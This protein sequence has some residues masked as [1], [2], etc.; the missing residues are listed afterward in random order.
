MFL[1]SHRILTPTRDHPFAVFART[2]LFGRL[3]GK[4]LVVK[5]LDRRWIRVVRA[6]RDR[7]AGSLSVRVRR[8]SE[9]KDGPS[10][11]LPLDAA[12]IDSVVTPVNCAYGD[13]NA[14]PEDKARYDAQ[15]VESSF[16]L[17]LR[18]GEIF[19]VQQRAAGYV[20]RARAEL[21]AIQQKV[22]GKERKNVQV[23]YPGMAM[24][25]NNGLPA[26]FGG[27][28]YDDII[29]RAGGV[30]AF[31]GK[32]TIALAMATAFPIGIGA[33]ELQRL[34]GIEVVVFSSLELT[35]VGVVPKVVITTDRSARIGEPAAHAWFFP[36]ARRGS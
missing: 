30:N 13:A 21:A 29:N 19:D 24:M 35:T 25:N 31:A 18:L 16:E 1:L 5:R 33:V 15:S 34:G 14:R 28:I 22:A 20:N 36:P 7:I 3:F 6:G 4:D 32:N 10:C 11:Q 12:G 27:G 2:L 17:L 26:I 8:T 9:R 23:A